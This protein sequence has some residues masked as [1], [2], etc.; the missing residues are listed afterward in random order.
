MKIVYL[1][2]F[3]GVLFKFI[4][5]IKQN[6][7]G[8]KEEER[9]KRQRRVRVRAP[10]LFTSDE[11][12]RGMKFTEIRRIL[13]KERRE[14]ER[15]KRTSGQF[16]HSR[17]RL[18]DNKHASGLRIRG[19]FSFTRMMNRRYDKKIHRIMK[20]SWLRNEVE[21]SV[22]SQYRFSNGVSIPD[23]SKGKYK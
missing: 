11:W 12:A 5:K 17:C 1:K 6:K 18:I 22:L 16:G 13:K 21:Y 19:H 3:L 14:K 10:N 4:V 9:T 8:R 20:R 7:Q 2:M 15:R 23:F